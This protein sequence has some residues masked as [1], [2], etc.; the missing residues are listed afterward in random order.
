MK[1]V[2]KEHISRFKQDIHHTTEKLKKL[3]LAAAD[4]GEPLL[5]GTPVP[6]YK[7]CGKPNCKCQQGGENRH[8]PYLAVQIRKD[9]KQ[10]NLTLK[11]SESHFFEMARE[12]QRQV[13]NR[14]S[15]RVLSQELLEKVDRILEARMIWD[16]Q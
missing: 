11:T 13:G 6:T 2:T 10:R 3:C 9:G 12:Y 14:E 5:A 1:K 8:G 7:T 15:I 4:D 16:K